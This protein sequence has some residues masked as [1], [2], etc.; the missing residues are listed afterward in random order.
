MDLQHTHQ[1]R[2]HKTIHNLLKKDPPKGTISFEN[3][4]PDP[5]SATTRLFGNVN[6][7]PTLTGLVVKLRFWGLGFTGLGVW[8]QSLGS[9][10]LR[11]IKTVS[12]IKLQ[13]DLKQGTTATPMENTT[14]NPKPYKL[15]ITLGSQISSISKNEFQAQNDPSKP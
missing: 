6:I 14:Q 5:N 9:R 1:C 10:K 2:P 12:S 8:G 11:K 15:A 13:S 3:P 4:P 7:S